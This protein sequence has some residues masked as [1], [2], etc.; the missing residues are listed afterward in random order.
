MGLEVT[1]PAG[2]FEKCVRV[3][4]TTPL[5]P[6]Q[7]V[8]IYCPGVG[9]VTDNVVSLVEFGSRSTRGNDDDE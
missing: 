5:E 7:T 4:E 1:T 8:K 3:V 6:G 9:L 2:T